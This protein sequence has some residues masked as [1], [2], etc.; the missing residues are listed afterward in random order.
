[1]K[2]LKRSAWDHAAIERFLLATR[3]PIRLAVIDAGVP[4]VASIWYQFDAASGALCCVSHRNARIVRL[5]GA[6]PA[7]GFE[8]ARDT[9][10][11]RGVRGQGEV[12]IDRES[13]GDVLDAL[14]RRYLGDTD[15]SLAR[16]LLGRAD[17]EVVLRIQPAWIT[18]WDF[19][20]R[21]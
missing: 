10:P 8:I 17:E 18:S 14:I 3:I 20:A 7:C 21:M 19:S 2:I 13:A 12:L 11:Y 16:W 6:N 15:S 1:M 9:S 5:L 4:L